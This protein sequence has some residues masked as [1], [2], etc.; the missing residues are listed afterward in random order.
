M[1]MIASKRAKDIKL[2][3]VKGFNGNVMKRVEGG[4]T[5]KELANAKWDVVQSFNV[6]KISATFAHECGPRQTGEAG[7]LGTD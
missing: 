1:T 3:K 7:R 2:L 6:W 5:N 4:A